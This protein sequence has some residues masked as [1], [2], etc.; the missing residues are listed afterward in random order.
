VAMV[1]ALWLGLLPA[2][3]AGSKGVF[4]YGTVRN[5]FEKSRDSAYGIRVL[6]TVGIVR[7]VLLGEGLCRV[8]AVS[9][10]PLDIGSYR[11]GI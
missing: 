8:C 1:I 11:G 2:A 4:V 6:K 9:Y 3:S 7:L 10:S 5:Y